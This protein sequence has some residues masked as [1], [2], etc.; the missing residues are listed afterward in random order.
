MINVK[1]ISVPGLDLLRPMFFIGI[2][3]VLLSAQFFSLGIVT[4]L[5]VRSNSKNDFKSFIDED[6]EDQ[7]NN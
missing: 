3:L 5:L 6:T 7:L 1:F 2:L 4:E